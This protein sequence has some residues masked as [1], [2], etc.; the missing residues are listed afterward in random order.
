MSL[1]T[2]LLLGLLGLVSVGLVA[3]DFIAYRLMQ[4]F[5][6]DRLD[7]QVQAAVDPVASRL[8]AGERRSPR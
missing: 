5:L 1:R 4:S 6:M 7:E 8:S 3:S 2:R